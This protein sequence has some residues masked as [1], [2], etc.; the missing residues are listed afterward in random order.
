MSKTGFIVKNRKKLK[1]YELE[2]FVFEHIQTGAKV[3]WLK[4]KDKERYFG[5]EFATFPED[6]TG[7]AH[8]LEH[9]VLH[10]SSKYPI[11]ASDPFAVMLRRR[12]LT[13]INASTWPDKTQYYFSA[14]N[15]SDFFGT[16]D[17]YLDGLFDPLVLREENIF[18]QEGW[19]LEKNAGGE[20]YYNGVVLNEMMS[21]STDPLRKLYE[22]AF[23]NMLSH[24]RPYAHNSGGDP[25]KIIDL[26][27][28][29]L[30]SFYKKYYTP[31]NSISYFYGDVDIDKALQML[32]IRFTDIQGKFYKP[33]V[34]K[35]RA[36]RITKDVVQGNPQ[37]DSYMA[38]G[39]YAC[40][41]K[42][43]KENMILKII[44][45]SLSSYESDKLKRELKALDLASNVEFIFETD[46]SLAQMYILFER[47]NYKDFKKA[48]KETFNILH[49]IYKKGLDANRINGIL[50]N[51]QLSFAK[52]KYKDQKGK[53]Y[54]ALMSNI[55]RYT[56]P[57]IVFDF[58]NI[59]LEIQ[60]DFNK[61]K[62][63]FDR[64]FYKHF[65]SAQNY[66]VVQLYAKENHEYFEEFKRKSGK[67]NRENINKKKQFESQI[68]D[69]MRFKSSS[70][71]LS[72]IKPTPKRSLVRKSQDIFVK[73][74]KKTNVKTYFNRID[75]DFTAID[76]F[77]DLSHLNEKELQRSV[78]LMSLLNKLETK[79]LTRTE[80]DLKIAETFD[81]FA[82]EISVLPKKNKKAFVSAR[83]SF[84]F[85]NINVKFAGL[86]VNSYINGM[87]INKN[88]ILKNLQE[89]ESEM[90][91]ALLNWY[92]CVGVAENYAKR[93][94]SEYYFAKDLFYGVGFYNFLQEEL[95]ENPK[96]LMQKYASLYEKM[97]KKE[98]LVALECSSKERYF[99]ENLDIE[100]KRFPRQALNVAKSGNTLFSIKGLGGNINVQ[101]FE[102]KN[103]IAKFLI[104]K[105]ILTYGFLWEKIRVKGGAYGAKFNPS[106]TGVMSFVS[107]NDPNI[108]NTYNVYEN[109]FLNLNLSS[110]DFTGAKARAIMSIDS[111]LS[112]LA[113][114]FK[115]FTD[116]LMGFDKKAYV[117]LKE[118]LISLDRE[119]LDM[120]AKDI[121]L[122]KVIK[123]TFSPN[124]ENVEF[125]DKFKRLN[126]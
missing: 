95:Q 125:F 11:V 15:N 94:Y 72:L 76:L 75:S 120:F 119:S 8:I 88:D 17:F 52:E 82:C 31:T 117:E 78:V 10:G 35:R 21:Y 77:F 13:D 83:F 92:S 34:H 7:V 70:D 50:K 118:E 61:D 40:P 96:T 114:P 9:S 36:S 113:E 6:D 86:I 45:S 58:E 43:V 57:D 32:D 66:G 37:G 104:L 54:F 110:D 60:D 33:S 56:N 122:K 84:D 49:S 18:R 108:L 16:L 73:K 116:D 109:A 111:P 12:Q 79:N 53:R 38:L 85:L 41:I 63:Y 97:F 26:S 23:S 42:N 19:R 100:N 71:D 24:L 91:N 124:E 115:M 69:F 74:S 30:K 102:F 14:V 99:Y 89:L 126:L 112:K 87:V 121:V 90:K 1:K 5:I 3:I 105:W 48:Q 62:S 98:G 123:T 93:G 55:W 2:Y 44:F 68:K 28:R 46:A 4:N 81:K 59:L 27:F 107:Y 67:L 64:Y 20:F 106:F 47:M 29:K 25:N 80:L 39:F 51:M 65:I 22:N 103:N 101:A